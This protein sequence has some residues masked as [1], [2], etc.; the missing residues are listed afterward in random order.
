[1]ADYKKIVPF[2]LNAEGGF[3]NNSADRGGMTNKGITWATWVMFNGDTTASVN[4][5]K[6]MDADDWGIIFKKGFWDKCLGDNIT[7]QAIANMIVDWVYTSGRYFPELHIQELINHIFNKHLAEDGIFGQ[8]TIDSINQ[9]DE[10]MLYQNLWQRREQYYK[11]I[12]AMAQ[13]KDDHSQD[14]FLKGWL[15]R[16]ENLKSFNLQS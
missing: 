12:V 13:S 1:M 11:D 7:S 16:V 15:N 8:T 5:F 14:G 4:R 9:A 10:D 2:I 3:V 6:V